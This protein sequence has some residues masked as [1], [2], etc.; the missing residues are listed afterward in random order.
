MTVQT[1]ILDFAAARVAMVDS[2]LRPQGVNYAPVA[3]AMAAIPREQ[4]VAEDVWPLAYSDRAVAIGDG[5]AMSSPTVLGLLLTELAPRAGERA[6][7]IGCGTGYSAAVLAEMGVEVVGLECSASLAAEARAK[8]IEVV[9][10]PLA[11]GLNGRAPFDLILVDGAVD[12]LPQPLLDQLA[13]NGRLAAALVDQGISR[14]TL[15]RRA[16]DGFGMQTLG[17]HGAAPLPGFD[18]PKSFTF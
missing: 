18:R 6:L 1:T 3:E 9:E 16:G 15:V 7:V 11:Q 12:H 14:L 4:F 10:G 8:G 2:Q 5:R 13:S 17:D